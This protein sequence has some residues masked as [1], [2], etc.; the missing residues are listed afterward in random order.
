MKWENI[1]LNESKIIGERESILYLS[2]TISFIFAYKSLSVLLNILTL[3]VLN[4]PVL[5]IISL[6]V[7]L[8]I[9]VVLVLVRPPG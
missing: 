1:I 2:A 3:L 6:V 4:L 9:L 8:S 7:V 5:S